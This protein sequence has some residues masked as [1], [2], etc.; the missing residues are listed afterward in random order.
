M[1]EQLALVPSLLTAHL[2]LTLVALL[3]GAGVSMPLGVWVTR[4]PALEP[5]VLGVASVIQTIPSLALL[6]IMVPTLAALG[7]LLSRFGVELRSIGYT[8]ALIALSLYSVLPI[9]RNTVAGIRGVDPALIEAARGVGMTDRQRLLRVELPLAMPVIVAGLRTATVWVVS[10]ATLSTPIGATSLGNFIFSGLAT[11]N[12]AAVLVGCIASAGLALFLDGMIRTLETGVRERSRRRVWIAGAALATLCLYTG[13]SFAFGRQA[14][15]APVVTIGS[16]AFTEQYILAQLLGRQIEARSG[17]ATR[18]LPSLG[19]TVAF[20]ALANGDIDVYVDYSGTIWATIMKRETLPERREEVLD[21]V[22]R[23]L[24]EIHGIGLV[25]SLGFENTYVLGMRAAH[26]RELGVHSLSELAPRTWALE[27][28]GDYE[29]FQRAEWKALLATYG[30]AFRERRS[31]DPAL[32]YQAV[33]EGEVDVISAFSTDGR[34]PAFDITLLEDD[35]GII[36][37]YDAVVLV[38]ARLR[39]ELPEVVAAL[40]ELDGAIDAETMQRMNLR[41]DGEGATPGEVAAEFLEGF[42]ERSPE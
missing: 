7:T 41:V 13:A 42:S 11:R 19:S 39:R 20:D 6:A 10:T 14:G 2:Q 17:F 29:F 8:P 4:R 16:K 22:S 12:D 5:G 24:D 25:A 26:A 33:A 30:F 38:S 1:A 15:G 9:L 34:I 23:F 40:R 31:M 32:M 27:I 28:G 3:I 18:S 21:E 36:P 37:P 35:R